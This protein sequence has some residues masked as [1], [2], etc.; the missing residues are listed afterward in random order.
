MVRREDIREE[1]REDL[2][3][4]LAAFL[5]IKHTFFVSPG[6]GEFGAL[7][8]IQIATFFFSFACA[9]TWKVAFCFPICATE[10]SLNTIV[11]GCAERFTSRAT[12]V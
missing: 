6:E 12:E 8:P 2:I 1:V 11:G 3:I 4:L 10:L 5:W 7:A 9:I